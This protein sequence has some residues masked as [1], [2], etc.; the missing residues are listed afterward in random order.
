MA[1]ARTETASLHRTT[2]LGIVFIRRSGRDGTLEVVHSRYSTGTLTV[3]VLP[4][5]AV[6][7]LRQRGVAVVRDGNRMVNVLPRPAT[8][9]TPIDPLS[10][11]NFYTG[12]GIGVGAESKL[13]PVFL[14]SSPIQT[15]W[16][17]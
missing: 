5:D 3:N 17:G 8:L 9:S 2:S 16:V 12:I 4:F 13:P 6:R 1:N 14:D 11:S 10:N 15:L 7:R